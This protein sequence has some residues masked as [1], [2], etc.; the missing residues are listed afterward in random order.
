MFS[1]F[2]F[3]IFLLHRICFCMPSLYEIIDAIMLHVVKLCTNRGAP[4][5]DRPLFVTK[6]CHH[7]IFTIGELKLILSDWLKNFCMLTCS[8]VLTFLTICRRNAG[9]LPFKFCCLKLRMC[10]TFPILPLRGSIELR[11]CDRCFGLEW[12]PFPFTDLLASN[13]LRQFWVQHTISPISS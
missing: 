5:Y 1:S 8:L 7:T 12:I 11:P 3:I 9:Y 13:I 6:R 10:P 2:V 4:I